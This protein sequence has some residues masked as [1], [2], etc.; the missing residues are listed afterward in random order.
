MSQLC[1]MYISAKRHASGIRKKRNRYCSFLSRLII[2]KW[3][4]SN[5]PPGKEIE[6]GSLLQMLYFPRLFSSHQWP[7]S[8]I[9]TLLYLQNMQ[10][11][12]NISYKFSSLFMVYFYITSIFFVNIRISCCESSSDFQSNKCFPSCIT[13]LL[14]FM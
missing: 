13:K 2:R 14:L 6:P 9:E 8:W 5:L 1:D 4:A 11:N 10:I 3:R 7:I 12:R